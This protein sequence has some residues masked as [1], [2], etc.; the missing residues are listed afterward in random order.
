MN[1]KFPVNPFSTTFLGLFFFIFVA[2]GAG[3]ILLGSTQSAFTYLMH[4]YVG[5]WLGISF[6]K[7]HYTIEKKGI[8]GPL[9][10]YLIFI[11]FSSALT[12]TLDKYYGL[13][14]FMYA[15]IGASLYLLF[16]FIVKKNKIPDFLISFKL[17]QLGIALLLLI[18]LALGDFRESALLTRFSSDVISFNVAGFYA[19]LSIIISIIFIRS[20]KK[21]VG[22][23]NMFVIGI[24]LAVLLLGLNKNSI[25]ILL[26]FILFYFLDF[27]PQ[28]KS[29]ASLFFSI[30]CVFVI[31]SVFIDN[32]AV[33]F[34]TEK[35]IESITSLTGRTF[36]WAGILSDIDGPFELFFGHGYGSAEVFFRES[37]IFS[38]NYGHAH[39]ALIQ[40]LYE[41]GIVGA[42]ILHVI[43]ISNLYMGYKSVR[44][45]GKKNAVI[46]IFFWV[47]FALLIRG[48]T[49]PGY[50]QVGSLDSYF[51]LLTNVFFKMK[52]SKKSPNHPPPPLIENKTELIS[53][54]DRLIVQ[55][56][57]PRAFPRK[58]ELSTE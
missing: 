15:L 35:G 22:L 54:G 20:K 23:T 57:S 51:L 55:R 29:I 10:A 45:Y 1:Y 46:N 33:L 40:S 3:G 11:S 52:M 49:E 37:K 5:L 32:L 36:I 24:G 31:S 30:L 27:K 25:A 42:T 18:W 7:N 43:L 9:L 48:L 13:K 17:L 16:N 4:L 14:A 44:N 12:Y 19:L 38:V 2:R 47:N 26:L 56:V 34:K 39:N 58:A 8:S 50:A 21:K 53:S 6:S 28:F 41:V